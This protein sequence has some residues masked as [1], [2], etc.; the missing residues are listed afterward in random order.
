MRSSRE[1][2]VFPE[3]GPESPGEVH[4]LRGESFFSSVFPVLPCYW[5]F[6]EGLGLRVPGIAR[7]FGAGRS[8]TRVTNT[9]PCLVRPFFSFLFPPSVAR[10]AVPSSF[11]RCLRY[12]TNREN[13]ALLPHPAPFHV[14][15][16]PLGSPLL[17]P[18][19]L[20]VKR[21][22]TLLLFAHGAGSVSQPVP[23]QLP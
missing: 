21:E 11:P 6:F 18:R 3:S 20:L 19:P 2:S 4:S 5:I 10:R 1:R 12:P 7:L 16:L 17:S 22:R 15:F 23:I 14:F 13:P 9:L 8:P